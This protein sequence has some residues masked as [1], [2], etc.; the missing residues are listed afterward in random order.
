M[1]LGI[2]QYGRNVMSSGENTYA[3]IAPE[4][5]S[6]SSNSNFGSRQRL[7][8]KSPK[9][10]NHHHHQA[11]PNVR[12]N[13]SRANSTSNGQCVQRQQQQEI[14]GYDLRRKI[15]NGSSGD[16]FGQKVESLMQIEDQSY[17][18]SYILSFIFEVYLYRKKI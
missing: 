4:T 17:G 15:A 18:V 9:M 14:F 2:H 12:V 10:H 16:L 8:S 7:D 1:L 13:L 3:S 11:S 5:T 6:Y